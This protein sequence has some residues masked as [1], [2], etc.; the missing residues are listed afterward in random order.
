M[1][2]SSSNKEGYRVAKGTTRPY[3][4]TLSQE[5]HL[6]AGRIQARMLHT[7]M[8]APSLHG[9]FEAPSLGVHFKSEQNPRCHANQK[10]KRMEWGWVSTEQANPTRG[11][12]AESSRRHRLPSPLSWQNL[13]EPWMTE[14]LPPT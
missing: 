12:W 6:G 4:I 13:K 2:I 7:P 5:E 8:P 3:G 11:Q 9:K 14:N 10:I 1:Q